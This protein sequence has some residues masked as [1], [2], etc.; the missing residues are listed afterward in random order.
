MQKT[1]RFVVPLMILLLL[2]GLVLLLTST[3]SHGKKAKWI[4]LANQAQDTYEII[5]QLNHYPEVLTYKE[6]T[7]WV[8][9]GWLKPQHKQQRTKLSTDY[10]YCHLVYRWCGFPNYC[11]LCVP[12]SGAIRC[13]CLDVNL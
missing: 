10:G 11:I 13:S 12:G 9:K 4:G 3:S 7:S 1:S 8:E 2:I 6:I 5:I